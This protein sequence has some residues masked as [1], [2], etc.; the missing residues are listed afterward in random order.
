MK[1]IIDGYNKI[2]RKNDNQLVVMEKD[3]EIY[4]ISANKISDITIMCKGH[5]TFDALNL[6]AKNNIKL[7]SINYFG[8]INY[9]L[10][11]PNQN[12]VSLKKSQYQASEN[13]KGLLISKEFIKSKMKNQKSTIKTLNKNKKIK[14]VKLIENTIKQKIKDF[15]NF[16]IISEDEIYVVKNKIMG[17]EGITSVNYWKGV[18]LLLPEDIN[19]KNRNQKPKNDVVNSMLNYGYAILA[20]EIAKNIV[21]HGLDPYCGFLHSDLKRRQSLIFDL[22]EE[23]RQQIVDKTVFKLVNNNQ[24]DETDIDKRNNSLKLESRKLLAS[25]IMAK[26]HSELTF[27]NEKV[28]YAKIIERQV[29]NLVK[30]LVNDEK[31]IGFYLNW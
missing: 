18:S 30:T 29:N 26:I 2:L 21:I 14:E 12:D 11:S 17:F 8:Q 9:I 13:Q 7:I 3:E 5:V 22:I 4:R 24:I 10:E 16:K 25:E 20:S 6:I 31:Y 28:S 15:K 19:F 1:L 23:F 27:D